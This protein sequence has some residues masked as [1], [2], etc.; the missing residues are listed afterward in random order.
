MPSEKEEKG[1]FEIPVVY[2]VRVLL[3]YPTYEVL[4]TKIC[5]GVCQ[6]PFCT[7]VVVELSAGLLFLS[8]G[9]CAFAVFW[10]LDMA[11]AR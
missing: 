3:A 5:P 6:E 11:A 2:K 8:G 1:H 7:G 4:K 10:Q 9:P